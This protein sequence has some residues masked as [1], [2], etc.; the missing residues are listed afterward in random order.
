[1]GVV[2]NI[3]VVVTSV[4]NAIATTA[5]ALVYYVAVAALVDAADVIMVRLSGWFFP[6]IFDFE[7]CCESFFPNNFA[8]E[9][10]ELSWESQ[11]VGPR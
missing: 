6:I 8:S 7:R 11:T 9:Q 10:V 4:V 3:G 5:V 1:M 2:A